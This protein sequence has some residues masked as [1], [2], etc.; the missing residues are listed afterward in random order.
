MTE[1]IRAGGGCRKRFNKNLHNQLPHRFSKRIC[2][3]RPVGREE[4]DGCANWEAGERRKED[5]RR[6][7]KANHA[8]CSSFLGDNSCYSQ[9]TSPFLTGSNPPLIRHE[10]LALTKR[11][12]YFEGMTSVVQIIDRKG[13]TTEKLR[14]Q[15]IVTHP[16][17]EKLKLSST[18]V[19]IAGMPKSSFG[20]GCWIPVYIRKLVHLA[21][22]SQK[23]LH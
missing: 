15:W 6:R 1:G 3:C 18:V 8:F 2:N 10:Q 12:L 20:F 22:K 16:E 14:E 9:N 7:K 23:S 21:M 19:V 17:Y 13:A 4:C 11:L 5:E